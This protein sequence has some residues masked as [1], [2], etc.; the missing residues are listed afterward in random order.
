MVAA[1]RH[2]VYASK[3]FISIEKMLVVLQMSE[4]FARSMA[5]RAYIS[6]ALVPFFLPPGHLRV[7]VGR[8]GWQN[9]T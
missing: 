9:G 6:N 5:P 7:V 3:S 2:A 1:G 4:R 8:I